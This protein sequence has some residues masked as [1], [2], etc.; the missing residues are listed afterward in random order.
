MDEPIKLN[1]DSKL[2]L[3][4]IIRSGEIKSDQVVKI[5]ELLNS[6]QINIYVD[7]EALSCKFK[8]GN[9]TDTK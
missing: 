9:K 1:K 8:Y 4:E 3:L 5:M 7:G 2:Y 6:P